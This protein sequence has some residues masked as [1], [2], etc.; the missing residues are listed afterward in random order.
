MNNIFYFL[1]LF[2]FSL[3]SCGSKGVNDIHSV[4]DV[5]HKS[6]FESLYPDFNSSELNLLLKNKFSDTTSLVD[7]FY[8]RNDYKSVWVKDTFDVAKIDTLLFYLNN[9]TEHGLNPKS[10][11]AESIKT[12]RDSVLNGSFSDSIPALYAALARL[13][14]KATTSVQHYTQGMRYGFVDAAKI[15]A[16]NYYIPLQK[17]DS[18][19]NEFVFENIESR[20]V[21]LLSEVQPQDSVYLQMQKALQSYRNFPDTVTFARI[22]LEKN[23]K[24]YRLNDIS[25][26]VMPLIAKRL[27]VTGELPQTENPDSVYRSLTPELMEAINL[28]RRN[29]SYPEDEEVG[30]ITIDALNRPISYYTNKIIANLE[31]YR[32]KRQTALSPKYIE[33]N[34]AAFHLIAV[35][36]G[37]P[38]L[39]MNVCAGQAF[40]NQTPLLESEIFYMNLN[41]T[42]SVPRSIIEKEMF[43]SI[44]K[45]PDYFKKNRMKVTHNGQVVNTDT[46][47]WSK[48]NNPKK[49]PFSVRQDAGEANSLGRIKFIFNN[50]FSVYLHDTPS[51]RAFNYTN[52]GVSHGCVRVQ[53]PMDL[54]FFCLAEKDSLYY[55]RL[56]YSVD[57][58]PLSSQG[59]ALHKQGKLT[60][61]TDVLYLSEKI[62]LFIDYF[63]VY[64][65]PKNADRLYFADD[66]YGFDELINKHLK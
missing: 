56:R 17:P 8:E 33:V 15:L 18:V 36:P 54:A 59:K 42:W 9:S 5:F 1:L 65:L 43:Y 28:F 58:L 12:L 11:G 37:S 44:K 26:S 45:N 66:V 31:R 34:V 10:F 35:E 23:V 61:L 2:S 55:D 38:T 29:N 57:Q 13:E 14:K 60:K 22:S 53:R 27:M 62:P 39:K 6:Q 64:A 47:D 16:G 21:Y 24:N 50:P 32:W 46:I 41:P 51:K 25:P 52:R 4:S 19:F 49:F 20:L 40:K 3:V 48:F 30:K 7:K 63:T